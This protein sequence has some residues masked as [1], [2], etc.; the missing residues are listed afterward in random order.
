MAELIY[1]DQSANELRLNLVQGAV[2]KKL[3]TVLCT[4]NIDLAY[5]SVDVGIIGASH[6][7]SFV[8][9][10]GETIFTEVF[11]CTDLD[12]VK[13]RVFFGDLHHANTLQQTFD[14]DLDYKFNAEQLNWATGESKFRNLIGKVQSDLNQYQIGLQFVFPKTDGDVFPPVTVVYA[15]ADPRHLAVAVETLHA[16]PN[17][18]SL[19]FTKTIIQPK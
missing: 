17:E 11:A 1:E 13:N 16:Y 7:F 12:R 10:S 8:N 2:D 4:G 6:Y 15:T 3:L 18:D 14:C 9:P 19:V 5:G